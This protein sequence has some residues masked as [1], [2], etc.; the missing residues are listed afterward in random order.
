MVTKVVQLSVSRGLPDA[1]LLIKTA[2]NDSNRKDH[3]PLGDVVK[4][5]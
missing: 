2:E 1:L 3:E 5:Y 4:Y